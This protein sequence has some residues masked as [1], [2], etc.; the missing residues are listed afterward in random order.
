MKKYPKTK[1]ILLSLPLDSAEPAFLKSARFVNKLS[2]YLKE[3]RLDFWGN[4]IITED[5]DAYQ[6]I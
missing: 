6:N 5:M 3:R 1:T 2:R 4:I